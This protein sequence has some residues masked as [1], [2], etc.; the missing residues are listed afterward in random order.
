VSLTTDDT[1]RPRADGIALGVDYRGART[2]T[3]DLG[4]N[5]ATEDDARD[6]FATLAKA[7]RADPIRRTSGAVAELHVQYRGRERVIYGRPRRLVSLDEEAWLGWLAVLADFAAVDDVY[8]GASDGSV[9]FGI[10]PPTGGGLVMPFAFPLTSTASSDRSESITVG[11]DLNAWPVVTFHG[12]ITNPSLALT[13]LWTLELAASIAAG[14]RVTVDTRPW[15]R[16]VLRNGSA[17]ASL[18][19]SLTRSSAR[20]SGASIPPGTYEAVLQGI[21]GTGTASVDITWRESYSS[22]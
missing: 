15:A 7:W 20:L 11:G 22:L 16:T 9:S 13:G 21:D 1:P 19:G 5:G 17:T 6:Q 4:V 8:Y 14:S 18:A 10:V 12:P 3:F 2:I